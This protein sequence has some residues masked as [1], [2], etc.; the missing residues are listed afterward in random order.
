MN[1]VLKNFIAKKENERR[2]EIEK[3]KE[4]FLEKH[5]LYEVEFSDKEDYDKFPYTYY[6]ELTGECRYYRT[7]PIKMTD[8]EYET[9]KKYE[10]ENKFVSSNTM[11]VILRVLAVL[12]I[13]VGSITGIDYMDDSMLEDIGWIVI[14]ASWISGIFIFGFAEIIQ[15]LHKILQKTEK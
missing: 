6:D 15:L 8:E 11:A 9:L 14:V 3:K 10:E 12:V 1:E 7:K 13:I 4:E 5:D 2:K